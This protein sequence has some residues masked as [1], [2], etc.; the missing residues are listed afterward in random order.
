[1]TGS[2]ILDLKMDPDR[3]DAGAETIREYFQAL[4]T[5]LFEKGEG[6]SG[7][8]PFGNSGWDYE[9]YVPLVKAGLIHGTL[10]EEGF[11]QQGD[12]RAAYDLIYK[13]IDAL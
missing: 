8:R 10:D 11:L 12:D 5:S 13:A 3:N 1:M 7:K 4:L 6:F 9:L 2:Q